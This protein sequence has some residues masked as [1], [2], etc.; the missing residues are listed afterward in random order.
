MVDVSDNGE[1]ADVLGIHR[2]VNDRVL[3]GPG[4]FN[5][6]KALGSVRGEQVPDI[7]APEMTNRAMN[8]VDQL[9]ADAL[10]LYCT[11]LGR[12]AGDLALTVNAHGGV[13]LSGSLMQRIG[14]DRISQGFNK[15]FTDKDKMT[16]KV[17]RIPVKLLRI[18][19]QCLLGASVWIESQ[20]SAAL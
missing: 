9:S 10:D 17:N 12:L 20:I 16:A 6:Y 1:V 11:L 8:R 3:S 18:K 13:Y 4:M 15:G 2:A 5:I 19:D 7:D 14:V